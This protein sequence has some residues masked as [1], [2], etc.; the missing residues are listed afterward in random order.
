MPPFAVCLALASAGSPSSIPSLAAAAEAVASTRDRGA[1]TELVRA[2]RPGFKAVARSLAREADPARRERLIAAVPAFAEALPRSTTRILSRT[3]RRPTPS[4]RLAALGALARVKPRRLPQL[5]M[6]RLADPDPQ[7]RT[8]LAALLA[9][10]ADE[11]TRRRLWR[12]RRDRSPEVRE[13]VL[14]VRAHRLGGDDQRALLSR[15]LRD[16]ADIV[17]W[18]AIELAGAT[19]DPAYS[20]ALAILARSEAPEEARRALMALTLLPRGTIS[21]LNILEDP[22]A[23][24]S[25]AELAFSWLRD[26][27]SHA[28]DLILPALED[29]PEDR[30]HQLMQPILTEPTDEELADLVFALDHPNPQRA[31]QVRIWLTGMGMRAD[32]AVA[33]AIVDARPSRAEVLRRYLQGRPGG[34]VSPE[35]LEATYEGPA[36]QRVAAIAAVGIIGAPQVRENLIGLLADA[37]PSVRAAAARAVA[38]LEGATAPLVRLTGDAA[39]EVRASAVEALGTHFDETAWRA[40]LGALRDPEEPVR[41]AAIRSLAGSSHPAALAG[42][43]ARI[44][45]GT[46]A[47]KEAAVVAIAESP[48][49]LAA[50]TLVELVVHPNPEVRRVALAYIDAL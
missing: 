36:E 43:E 12:R 8:R 28:L 38:D 7:V 13:V 1:E 4:D 42:L 49:T 2:G 22:Q 14:R 46:A 23:P 25:S 17:R 16:R 27:R 21:V 3:L 10:H 30:R 15:G 47:E 19:R 5:L 41:L 45:E 6:T 34:G 35:M 33:A 39:P 24:L 18:A 20:E 29:L 26:A 32:A 9:V 37:N 31:R 50:V 48:T 40:R 44:L 11:G